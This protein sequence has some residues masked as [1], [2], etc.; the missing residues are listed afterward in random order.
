MIKLAN[1]LLE[2]MS[3]D[4]VQAIVDRVFPQIVKD[5]GLGKQGLPELELWVDIYAR[6]SDDPEMRGEASKSTKEEWVYE[7]NSIY[8]YYPNMDSEEDVIRSVL[9]EFEHTHQDEEENEEY[10]KL[11]YDDN[12]NEIAAR[13]AERKWRKYLD[14]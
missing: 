7:E 11:G 2:S 5:R 8:I 13:K 14:D 6:L 1:L 3:K 9:H 12:P 4:E 10:R